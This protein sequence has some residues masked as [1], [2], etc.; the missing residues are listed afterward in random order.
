MTKLNEFSDPAAHRLKIDYVDEVWENWRAAREQTLKRITGYLFILNTGAM[1]AALTYVAAKP[2][3]GEIQMAIWLFAAGIFLSVIHATL[4]YYLTESSFSAFR[5]DVDQFYG[6]KLDWE[7]FIDRN[8]NRPPLDC[9]LHI[10]GW[11][12]GLSFFIGLVVGLWNMPKT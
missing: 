7:V 9:L 10:L 6:N 12:G 3:N 11:L 4:D 1:L 8:N 5:K 2:S